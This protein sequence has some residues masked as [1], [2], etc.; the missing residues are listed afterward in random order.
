METIKQLLD[1]KGREIWS[2]HPNDSVFDAIKKMAD[3]DIGSLIVLEE[4]KIV[5]F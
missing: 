5:G 2:V 3:K 1:K 4:D